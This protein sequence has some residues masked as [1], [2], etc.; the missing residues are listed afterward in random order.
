[1]QWEAIESEAKEVFY[2]RIPVL[3]IP[4]N[5]LTPE[6]EATRD[7]QGPYDRMVAANLDRGLYEGSDPGLD[8]CEPDA[9]TVRHPSNVNA[10]S[11]GPAVFFLLAPCIYPPS[12]FRFKSGCA[13]S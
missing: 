9:P 13:Q 12:A 6:E 5:G 1:M 8:E 4:F 2:R 7:Q 3:F 10:L 11:V